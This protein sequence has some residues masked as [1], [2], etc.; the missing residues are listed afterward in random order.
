MPK[1]DKYLKGFGLQQNSTLDG[2]YLSNIHVGHE[3]ITRY[4]EYQYPTALT[5]KA[6]EGNVDSSK[7]IRD[8]TEYLAGDQIIYSEYGNPYS[9]NFGTL[10]VGSQTKDEVLFTARGV[11]Y[12]V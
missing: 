5:W 9:C 11:C 12:R 10:S 2:F 7:L 1:Q 8:L 3:V 6:Y 4:R